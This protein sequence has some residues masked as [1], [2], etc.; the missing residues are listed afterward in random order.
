MNFLKQV[1]TKIKAMPLWLKILFIVILILRIP[2]LFYPYAYGDE[3]IYLTLGEA[4]RRRVTLYGQIHDNKPPL[5]YILAS[6]S[7]S[8]FWFRTILSFWN[9]ATIYLYFLVAKTFFPKRETLVKATTVLFALL[10][11]AP[12]FE[13]NIA[14]AE[15]FMLLPILAGIL[16]LFCGKLVPKKVFL[17]GVFF[18]LAALFKIPAAFDFAAVFI[19][20]LLFASKKLTKDWQL[21]VKTVIFFALGFLLPILATIAYYSARGALSQY[22]VAAFLQNIG[23]L[24]SWQ[25]GSQGANLTQ[26]GLLARGIILFVFTLFLFLVR[27]R[28]EKNSLFV[29]LWFSF[30][31]FAALLSERPYPHYLVQ[32]LPSLSLLAFPLFA[33]KIPGKIVSAALIFT[34]FFFINHISFWDYPTLP[35]YK[36][37]I[38]FAVG[39]KNQE[40]FL[41]HFGG[42]VNRNYRLAKFLSENTQKEEKIFVWGNSPCVYALSR[43]L[44]VGRYTASYHIIDFGGFKQTLNEIK[45]QKP[46]FV[47]DLKNENRPFPGFQA[48]LAEDYSLYQ[49]IDR[50]DIYIL[51]PFLK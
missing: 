48:F 1:E 28:F 10:S 33:H 25:A 8:L 6:I 50:V 49:K 12:F 44:P 39:A 45:A 9:L 17:A 5:L 40:E 21:T 15:I 38:E 2:S 23:Y 20:L 31:L 47:V 11:T 41:N 35:Y 42:D 43:R 46:R 22:L 24:S 13:G 18:S 51:T 34:F 30:S 37:F 16:L 14:N 29:F 27:A 7:G 3:C 36:N 32:V 19:F 4:I 26:S